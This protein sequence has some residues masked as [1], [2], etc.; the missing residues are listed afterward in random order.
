MIELLV[1]MLI[2]S[3]GLLGIGQLVV[4]VIK[5]NLSSRNNSVATLLAQDGIEGLKGRNPG[6]VASTTED[7]RTVPGFPHY[8]R[9]TTVEHN[10]PEPGVTTVTV[11]VHWDEDARSVVLTTM[12]SP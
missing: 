4:G 11:T 9:V 12:L 1:A 7:Y 8:K 5:G 2:L 10:R 3:T 6:S